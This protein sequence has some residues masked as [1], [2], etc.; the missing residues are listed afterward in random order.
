MTAADWE[1]GYFYMSVQDL[2]KEFLQL[3]ISMLHPT[4]HYTFAGLD[5]GEKKRKL[6]FKF[7]VS[8]PGHGY[9]IISQKGIRS[10]AQNIQ[11]QVN[12]YFIIRVVVCK[13]DTYKVESVL[14]H[15]YLS[16]RDCSVECNFE[17]AG[18]YFAYIEVQEALS[19]RKADIG[20]I[21]V[22][23]YSSMPISFQ[24]TQPPAK[25]D[26]IDVI[27]SSIDIG[28]LKD[29]SEKSNDKYGPGIKKYIG[30]FMGFIVFAYINESDN[31]QLNEDIALE[32]ENIRV[33]R[34]YQ[35]FKN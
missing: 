8:A 10:S 27:L 20:D 21:T 31:K 15:E 32:A 12:L 18:M 16:N 2:R 35:E 30:K 13:G 34:P 22:S 23:T 3:Q 9:F 29:F 33:C 11:D 4:Y 5:V 25:R 24:K 6:V 7:E 19:E 26:L 1:Q 17:C 14:G 28:K